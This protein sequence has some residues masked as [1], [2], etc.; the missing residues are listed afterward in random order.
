MASSP[1]LT[2]F[3]IRSWHQLSWAMQCMPLYE[4]TDVV[5][6]DQGADHDTTTLS[7]QVTKSFTFHQRCAMVEIEIFFEISAD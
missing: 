5:N 1:T 2:S 3:P 7:F 6:C 4:E